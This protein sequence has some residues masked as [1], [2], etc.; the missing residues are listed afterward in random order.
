MRLIQRALSS[1]YVHASSSR[2]PAARAVCAYTSCMGDAKQLRRPSSRGH[3]SSRS[4]SY[5]GGK[6]EWS[7]SIGLACTAL[8]ART[9]RHTC[10]DG[11]L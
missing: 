4:S 2:Q 1:R 5:S 3:S 7:A 10:M 8:Q 11:H 6:R 9:N